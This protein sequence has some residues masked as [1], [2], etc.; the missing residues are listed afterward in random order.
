M[1]LPRAATHLLVA[2]LATSAIVGVNAFLVPSFGRGARMS[3]SSSS[4]HRA[5]RPTSTLAM[6]AAAVEATEIKEDKKGETF[7]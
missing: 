7:E 3:S 1:K 4:S 5:H 2:S 6:S